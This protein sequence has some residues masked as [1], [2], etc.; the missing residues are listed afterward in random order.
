MKNFNEEP[1]PL[2]SS[3]IWIALEDFFAQAD[4]QGEHSHEILRIVGDTLVLGLYLRQRP[5]NYLVGKPLFPDRTDGFI[6]WIQKQPD[7]KSSVEAELYG[8]RNNEER[9]FKIRGDVLENIGVSETAVILSELAKAQLL[10]LREFID[11]PEE[12]AN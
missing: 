7:P 12:F 5:Y 11:L 1:E 2:P 3:P 10:P 9:L 4:L 8:A 6:Y